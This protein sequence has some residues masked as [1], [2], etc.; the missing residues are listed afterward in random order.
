MEGTT[1][2]ACAKS[3]GIVIDWVVF[4]DTLQSKLSFGL[5]GPMQCI[6]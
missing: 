2:N 5:V 3:S 1:N 6:C 4:L